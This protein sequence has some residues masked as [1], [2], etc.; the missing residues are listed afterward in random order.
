MVAQNDYTIKKQNLYLS[1]S[2]MKLL[3]NKANEAGFIGK[4]E[5]SHYLEYLSHRDIIIIDNNAKKIGD[6]LGAALG[7]KK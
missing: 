5:I 2:T 7:G 6:L 4:G 1:D 3:K